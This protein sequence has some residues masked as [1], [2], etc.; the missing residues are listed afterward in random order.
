VKLLYFSDELE[1]PHQ[2]KE[3]NEG[4]FDSRKRDPTE[5]HNPEV[6]VVP[7]SLRTN[8]MRHNKSEEACAIFLGRAKAVSDQ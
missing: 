1:Q 2:A 4:D 5:D 7:D 6:K 8:P 3:T